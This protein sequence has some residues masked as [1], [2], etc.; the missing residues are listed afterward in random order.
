MESALVMSA[1]SMVRAVSADA[2]MPRNGMLTGSESSAEP[3]RPTSKS[4]DG[5]ASPDTISPIVIRP[6]ASGPTPGSVSATVTAAL[7]LAMPSTISMPMKPKRAEA[8]TLF[9]ASVMAPVSDVSLRKS[10]SVGLSPSKAA[11]RSRP[12]VTLAPSVAVIAASVL[13]CRSASPWGRSNPAASVSVSWKLLLN[14][15]WNSTD[16]VARS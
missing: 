13:K 14:V 16:F 15:K 12:S 1:K 9:A 2:A 10:H 5:L 4:V 8:S 3:L 6:S 11:L 7:T